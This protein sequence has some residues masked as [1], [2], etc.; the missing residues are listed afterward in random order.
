LV[1]RGIVKLKPLVTHL[2]PL[3]DLKTAITMLESDADQRMKII[4]EH[5]R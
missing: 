3:S 2:V 1:A 5:S 4:L